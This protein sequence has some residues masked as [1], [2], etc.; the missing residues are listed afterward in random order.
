MESWDRLFWLCMLWFLLFNP[1]LHFVWVTTLSAYPVGLG[2]CF[3]V[4]K[5]GPCLESH[6]CRPS[7]KTYDGLKACLNLHVA[8]RVA[9]GVF[10]LICGQDESA[11]AKTT[12]LSPICLK[13]CCNRI[14]V[15]FVFFFIANIQIR[16]YWRRVKWDD[17]SSRVGCDWLLDWM[18]QPGDGRIR[19]ES[20]VIGGRSGLA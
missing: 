11:D 12:T 16:P 4:I 7:C 3:L 19:M 18:S 2:Y 6:S 13:L 1:F 9:P 15:L 10:V 20:D 17:E 8:S 14:T 5:S